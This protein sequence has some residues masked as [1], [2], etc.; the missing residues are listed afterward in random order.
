M[1]IVRAPNRTQFE[2]LSTVLLRDRRLSFRARGIACRLLSN[3]D[4]Y[5]MTSDDLAKESP[6]GR[7]A[8]LSA[9]RELETFGYLVRER[10]RV[11]GGRC[12][13]VTT[14]YEEPSS[15][16]GTDPTTKGIA[17]PQPPKAGEADAGEPDDRQLRSK[18]STTTFSTTTT[19]IDGLDWTYLPTLTR[20]DRSV[21]VN[22]TDGLTPTMQQDLL[23]ELAGTLRANAIKKA[24]PAWM[25]GVATS[26]RQGTFVPCHALSIRAERQRRA[27]EA[28]AADYRRRQATERHARR[29]DPEARARS[30]EFASAAMAEVQNLLSS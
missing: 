18:S 26:A 22:L 3:V 11:T 17:I 4:G 2:K 28:T 9:L 12:I 13:T 1:N 16:Q 15:G 6:E 8:V 10:R 23:D 14:F 30:R 25:R 27:E 21:V 19:D 29:A 7:H 24:W 20:D 5:R